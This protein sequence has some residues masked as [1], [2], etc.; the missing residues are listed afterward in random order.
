MNILLING[1]PKGKRSNTYKLATSFIDGIKEKEEVV[2]EELFVNKLEINPCVGCFSCWNKTPGKCVIK[3]D[4]QE[5][6]EKLLWADITIWSFPLYYF[7]VPSKLKTLIDRQLPMV[8]PFMVKDAESGSHPAR[9]DMSNKRNVLISTCGFYTTEGNYDAVISMFNHLLGKD[10]YEKIFC[11]QGELFR[12]PELSKRTNEYLG[13]VKNAGQEYITSKI[14][15]TTRNKL[16]TLLFPKET[17]EAMADA[18]WGV[19]KETG[20]KLDDSLIFTKQ[21]AALYNKKSYKGKD[22]VLEMNYTDIDKSYQIILKRDSYEVITENFKPFTTK[23]E[24]PFTVWCDIASEKISGEEALMKQMYKVK[25][26][27]DLMIHWDNYF[28]DQS[29]EVEPNKDVKDNAKT[30]MM[31]LLLPWIVFWIATSINGYNGS[32]ISI[33]SCALISLLFYKNK[34]TIYDVISNTAIIIFSVITLL[35]YDINILLPISYLVFGLMW[36]I[37]CLNR[38]PLT[39]YY[40]ANDYNGEKAFDNPLF[41]KTNR[42]L[43]FMWGILYVLTSVMTFFV[44]KTSFSEYLGII[45]NI[46]PIFM[47]IF[48]AW[49]QK[50]YPAKVAR[51]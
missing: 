51:G 21:M 35:E 38:I 43:T 41:I 32:F 36:L 17:F 44:M 11:S 25:G 15:E 46:L 16:N 47:G 12:V 29:S 31:I 4:M 24:T 5:V 42:I 22:I 23:I 1:S 7:S 50:W 14:K 45:N 33:A 8:L 40:S 28:G 13:Y 18:S 9:Y 48:T 30:N 20:E 19:E 2:L 27:F 49:F 3:D 10:N 6:I 34:K 26:D 37:S 39:A